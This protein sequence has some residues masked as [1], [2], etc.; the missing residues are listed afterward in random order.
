[1]T[2][3][4]SQR[5]VVSE[6]FPPPGQ[7]DQPGQSS[8]QGQQ[9]GY[10]QTGYGQQP[11]YTQTVRPGFPPQQ[12]Y[13]QQPG[14]GQGQPGGYGQGQGQQPYGG[15]SG[16]PYGGAPSSRPNPLNSPSGVAQLVTIAGY[17]VTGLGLLAAILFLF[18]DVGYSGSTA[19][20]IAQACLALVT[21][22]GFGA[23]CVGLGTLIKQRSST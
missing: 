1:M 4:K 20:K 14:Y 12:G 18:T 3:E 17:V 13:G 6:S 10:P 21:G 11:D 19:F 8:Q 23:V 7:P 2:P 5:S 15:Y 16:Q 22:L 9:G